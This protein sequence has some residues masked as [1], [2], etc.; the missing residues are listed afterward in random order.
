MFRNKSRIDTTLI[1]ILVICG[2]LPSLLA[3]LTPANNLLN[4]F[5]TDDA[6]YYFKVA[7][8]ATTGHGFTFDGM[9]NTNGFHPLWMAVCLVAFWFTR[10]NLILPLRLIV[11]ISG[12]L[13]AGSVLLLYRLL[14][15]HL[16][17]AVAFTA[18]AAWALLPEIFQ[19]TTMRGLETGLSVFCLLLLLLK[20]QEMMEGSQPS[21]ADLLR[22]GIL[23]ALAILARLDNAFYVVVICLFYVFRVKFPRQVVFIDLLSIAASSFFA[24]MVLIAFK[25]DVVLDYSVYPLL[26][27]ALCV[28]PLLLW[29]VG[30]YKR[31]YKKT[32]K[33][34][35]GIVGQVLTVSFLFVGLMYAINAMGWQVRFSKPVIFA[36]VAA[37]IGLLLLN[38]FAHWWF[39]K[40]ETESPTEKFDFFGLFRRSLFV[41]LPPAVVLFI[42]V[43]VNKILFFS[44]TPVSGRVK[45]FW[46]TFDNT[47][48]TNVRNLYDIF[49]AGKAMNPFASVTGPLKDFAK[50]LVSLFGVQNPAGDEIAYLLVCGLITTLLAILLL[51]AP[52]KYRGF[53][54]NLMIPA[55]LIGSIL[56]VTFY[57]LYGYTAIRGW[58]WITESLLLLL[59]VVFFVNI[60]VEWLT[61]FRFAEKALP[62]AS[63]ALVAYFLFIGTTFVLRSVP[64]TVAADQKEAYL[65]EVRYLESITPSGSII[66][67]TGS[68]MD[69]YFIQ[70]RTII[71]LDG[72]INSAQ[73]LQSMQ[74]GTTLDF[75]KRTGMQYVWG[76]SYMLLKADPYREFFS[77][78][79]SLVENVDHMGNMQLFLFDQNCAPQQ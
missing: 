67:M 45:H 53:L 77:G 75:L 71:N 48:Y 51:K 9:N 19:V 56:R 13:N 68:G 14:V 64:L 34:A 5:S 54:V 50:W 26:V 58:Y 62:F 57:T 49:G 16:H 41:A 78:C 28:K 25:P 27:L 24:W 79:L 74:D 30:A 73:Y 29:L 23:A 55:L 63:A 72:L 2:F 37:T 31:Y 35:L 76:N 52:I 44:A 18:A 7:Q 4:W 8:N 10:I 46:S 66:G 47:P 22:L 61:R 20:V 39:G 1:V 32:I 43:M 21:R 36:D 3:S 42:Y 60:L 65:A 70:G 17:K 69:G 40:E 59:V 11:I 12:L 38:H 15:K 6:F 33:H